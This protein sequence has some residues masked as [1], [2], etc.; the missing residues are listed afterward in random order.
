MIG[1]TEC[2]LTIPN[3]EDPLRQRG[4]DREYLCHIGCYD[5]KRNSSERDKQMKFNCS[6]A[7]TNSCMDTLTLR[8]PNNHSKSGFG[9][10]HRPGI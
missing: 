5:S 7:R 2:T 8:M 1:K 4:V 3:V 10:K 6:L 9:Y